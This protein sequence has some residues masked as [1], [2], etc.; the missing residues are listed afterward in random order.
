MKVF[1]STLTTLILILLIKGVTFGQASFLQANKEYNMLAF[2]R[3]A[4]LY[5]KSLKE[6]FKDSTAK[7]DAM[8]KLA[9]SYRQIRD[10]RNAERV[11]RSV[12]A[13]NKDLTG[14]NVNCYLYYAQALAS[15][16]KLE[17]SR[18]AYEKFDKI[19]SEDARGKD[20]T[21]LYKA[22]AKLSK[23]ATSYTVEY[24]D[25]NT[26]RAEF[27]P[28]YYKKGIVFVAARNE[29]TSVKRIYT[30]NNTAF[31]DLYELPD[32]S[33]LNKSTG[34]TSSLGGSN[35]SKKPVKGSYMLGKDEYT[36]PTPNDSKLVGYGKSYSGNSLEPLQP[37]PIETKVLG[38]KINSKYHEGQA[39][40]FKDGNK[41]LFTRNNY[42]NGK[43][44]E[45]KEG[46]NKLKL[47]S[48]DLVKEEWTNIKELPFNSDEYSTGD[49]SL[50]RDDK[51][52]YF[53]SDMPGG[54]GGTDIYVVKNENGKWST[55]LNLGPAVNT[56]GNE[57][58]PFVDEAG[59]LY[60]SSDGHAG[61]GDLDIFYVKLIDGVIAKK[62][63]NLG[64]PINSSKDDFG[65]ITDGERKN[66]YFSSNRKRGG[67]DD[68]IYRFSRSGPLQACQELV[69]KVIDAETKASLSN[70]T[71]E[72]SNKEGAD[73]EVKS[74]KTDSE[75]NLQLCLD[76]EN[77]YLFKASN[78][79]Y[80]NN[81][82]SFTTKDLDDSEIAQLEIPLDKI[83]LK[84]KTFRITGIV[85]TQKDKK[86]IPGVKV[87]LR[88][89]CD[90]TIQ[91][92]MTDEAGMYRF[93]IPVGCDYTIEA[94][95]DNFGTM[96]SHVK[97]GE[98][99]EANFT[100]FEKGDV[101][102][103]DNI[104]YDLNK[105]K[106]RPDAE[107]EL[108]RLVEMMNK[109]P[110]MKIEFGSH[111]DSRSSTKYN[112]TLSTKRAKAAVAYIVKKGID[113]KR[114][115]AAGYGESKPVNKCKDGV[116]CT[117][118]EHQQNRRTEIKILNL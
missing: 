58:F 66:G 117:E 25:I 61:L 77:D 105:W 70:A 9:H 90:S 10:T 18:D 68:D 36:S 81:N 1:S 109:Y 71:V 95:K 26:N 103:I 38:N 22:P 32:L 111:T 79:G 102:R 57:R 73:G 35:A 101:I 82:L 6:S 60:F 114:V 74:L 91:E 5:E 67:A 65:I 104:Y 118:E 98:N 63:T 76:V 89:E 33:V 51:L 39:T 12:I 14:E 113:A 69:V 93:E 30:W 92:A 48:A 40:F 13:G 47:Y 17:E 41:M 107:I 24:L 31:L 34:A 23:N 45:S 3:A 80:L 50:S 55:P 28:T 49:P 84:P 64:S 62:A 42:L 85:S 75:G 15:N 16:G 78:E 99:T 88:N 54:L 86:P 106:I 4:E 20:F 11:Y 116:P 112:K 2:A 59:N 94:L 27:S 83:K 108:N 53:V 97:G 43:Y 7:L 87:I 110:K 56:K 29:G 52:L 100:M 72:L 44:G 8:I 21:K 115:V 19:Q 37:S 46:I 96:G